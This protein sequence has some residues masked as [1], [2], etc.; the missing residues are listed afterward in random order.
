MHRVP[1]GKSSLGKPMGP[2]H[3]IS[4]IGGFE[5]Y[6]T[7]CGPGESFILSKSPKHLHVLR[8]ELIVFDHIISDLLILGTAMVKGS[9]WPS[10]GSW[11]I[12]TPMGA[13]SSSVWFPLDRDISVGYC[14]YWGCLGFTERISWQKPI[15]VLQLF[16]FFINIFKNKKLPFRN[17]TLLDVWIVPEQ[18]AS[19]GTCQRHRVWFRTG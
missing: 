9:T 19:T 12:T 11:T 5:V 4:E 13:L 15:L 8:P 7:L 16:N 18:P 1:W 3:S 17:R 14:H 10:V 6:L 2:L